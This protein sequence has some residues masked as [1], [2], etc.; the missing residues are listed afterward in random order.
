[1]VGI[2]FSSVDV[3]DTTSPGV[4]AVTV[5][6]GQSATFQWTSTSVVNQLE[7]LTTVAVGVVHVAVHV[8][9]RAGGQ[10]GGDHQHDQSQ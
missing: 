4:S 6:S 10:G 9:R 5:W 8:G 7:Q 3:H 2:P 1:V